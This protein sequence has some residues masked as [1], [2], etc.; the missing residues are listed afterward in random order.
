MI[1]GKGANRVQSQ[2]KGAVG[3][4][5][6]LGFSLKI[7]TLSVETKKVSMPPDR[8]ELPAFSFLIGWIMRLTLYLLS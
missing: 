4:G 6:S 5:R 7:V 8:I 1:T 2:G 3:N